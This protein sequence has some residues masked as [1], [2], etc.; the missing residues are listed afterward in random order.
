[1]QETSAGHKKVADLEVAA[2]FGKMKQSALQI[3]IS[4]SSIVRLQIV[5]LK[6]FHYLNG[7]WIKSHKIVDFPYHNLDPMEYLAAIPATTLR[8][9][10]TLAAMKPESPPSLARMTSETIAEMCEPNSLE[11]NFSNSHLDEVDNAAAAAVT[12]VILEDAIE[13]VIGENGPDVF[14]KDEDD[15]EFG[16]E[17]ADGNGLFSPPRRMRQVSTSLIS[18][19]VKDDNLEDFHEHK[20]QNGASPLEVNYNLYGMVVSD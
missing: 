19:P 4:V 6:R 18:N 20:L 7:R 3:G 12:D 8:R 17:A 9:H 1:M 10:K 13:D 14:A 16:A 2:H 11:E 15:D 5:H